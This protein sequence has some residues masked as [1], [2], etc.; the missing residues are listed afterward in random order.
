MASTSK[1]AKNIITSDKSRCNSCNAEIHDTSFSGITTNDMMLQNKG[2]SENQNSLLEDTENNNNT[3]TNAGSQT[4]VANALLNLKSNVDNDNFNNNIDSSII[5]I[6]K[7][8]PWNTTQLSLPVDHEV[9]K[10]RGLCD[11]AD[12]T[13]DITSSEIGTL[14]PPSFGSLS[15]RAY[16]PPLNDIQNIDE[17]KKPKLAVS[18]HMNDTQ[19]LNL[20]Y[21]N[22][23][24]ETQNKATQMTCITVNDSAI[25]D[26]KDLEYHE[27]LSSNNS[28]ATTTED[29]SEFV[30]D[31]GEKPLFA[32]NYNHNCN[33]KIFIKGSK[34]LF[35][36]QHNITYHIQN[37]EVD[38]I[39]NDKDKKQIKERAT[40]IPTVTALHLF[41]FEKITQIVNEIKEGR[42]SIR[43]PVEFIQEISEQWSGIP[44][45][46]KEDFKINATVLRSVSPSH[47]SDVLECIMQA[48][49]ISMIQSIVG[50]NYN[51]L[52]I[53]RVVYGHSFFRHDISKENKI[54]T[55][56]CQ[57][58]INDSLS[59][60]KLFPEDVCSSIF[61]T[62]NFEYEPPSPKIITLS[63]KNKSNTDTMSVG[64]RT[65]NRTMLIED[66]KP[67]T[68]PKPY[69]KGNTGCAALLNIIVGFVS[70]VMSN[71]NYPFSIKDTCQITDDTEYYGSKYN[72]AI[73]AIPKKKVD[74]KLKSY[75]IH[76]TK[77]N[78]KEFGH[79][80]LGLNPR[81][82]H[83]I[84]AQT[85]QRRMKRNTSKNVP[86]WIAKTGDYSSNNDYKFENCVLIDP[87]VGVFY[88]ST[89]RTK[90]GELY[91]APIT[92]LRLWDKEECYFKS[93]N[94]CYSV[95]VS[96]LLPLRNVNHHS[97]K[98]GDNVKENPY[99]DLSIYPARDNSLAS[100]TANYKETLHI[101]HLVRSP[102]A[103]LCN[104]KGH[105]DLSIL[106]MTLTFATP[107]SLLFGIDNRKFVYQPR[108]N[109]PY[110][111]FDIGQNRIFKNV[112]NENGDYI[113]HIFSVLMPIKV[114]PMTNEE[115]K[116]NDM[117]FDAEAY[118]QQI[119]STDYFDNR[120]FVKY[121]R[122][123]KDNKTKLPPE[124]IRINCSI[125]NYPRIK[126][127]AVIAPDDN[128]EIVPYS[129]TLYSSDIENLKQICR[130]HEQ[131]PSNPMPTI[132]MHLSFVIWKRLFN[133][134]P[135]VAQ[136]G[137]FNICQFILLNR[138]FDSK[139]PFTQ[140]GLFPE[141]GNKNI[142]NGSNTVLLFL[143]SPVEVK[144]R[145]KGS[146]KQSEEQ[147]FQVESG[148]I[149]NISP[150][151]DET[152]EYAV[153]FPKLPRG[154]KKSDK[155]FAQLD[156]CL[157]L[158]LSY[159]I[160]RK[161]YHFGRVDEDGKNFNYAI[162]EL[163]PP[164]VDCEIY[165]YKI[166][167]TPFL[168]NHPK[169]NWGKDL[170]LSKKES[171]R[172][173]DPNASKKSDAKKRD[174]SESDDSDNDTKKTQNKQL[175]RPR[176]KQKNMNFKSKTNL[177]C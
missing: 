74:E 103:Y 75:G 177:S 116:E 129:V 6:P 10:D 20:S 61:P 9:D 149:L 50:E 81:G 46:E 85:T 126:T 134:I 145:R 105:N 172:R 35:S 37:G 121:H 86:M 29:Y 7:L 26:N 31:Q 44:K 108:F 60:K 22:T 137:P 144:F 39:I 128:D 114:L 143:G 151:E 62:I 157:I 49:H 83:Y 94:D 82:L 123:S 168:N 111:A 88:D 141:H 12:A 78:A 100:S 127:Y 84:W 139:I 158:K 169:C 2:S 174:D 56:L 138:C 11:S 146:S 92:L 131:P 142:L 1:D 65:S 5:K 52:Q 162:N 18:Q 15:D 66:V 99:F 175:C 119:D 25:N 167:H 132:L 70:P 102:F 17:C 24:A 8:P 43:K 140:E 161:K 48:P 120:F 110:V 79:I 155:I 32:E 148:C 117:I 154:T 54:R 109:I 173:R 58:Q 136:G 67:H 113:N 68:I 122:T 95:V 3:S 89:L 42:I 45:T 165:W 104:E 73:G 107:E 76:M 51:T 33:I 77:I 130:L 63:N 133:H 19:Q 150:K 156:Y 16:S 152:T 53:A 118:A 171:P 166:K 13:I 55:Y 90:P 38:S 72:A 163:H 91:C 30:K 57:E 125:T 153:E 34:P 170:I 21:K 87:N 115:L 64:R 101:R 147:K 14:D 98:N 27:H 59:I 159:A 96:S 80:L 69:R 106:Q 112:I 40:L 71:D 164:F 47:T 135:F 23:L 41:G 4:L 124:F 176:K 36:T 97:I 28:E 160:N 93:I